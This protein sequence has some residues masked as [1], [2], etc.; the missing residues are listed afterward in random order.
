MIDSFFTS[1]ALM[2]FPNTGATSINKLL[3]I[4]NSALRIATGYVGMTAFDHFHSEASS[5]KVDEH[6]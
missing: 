3:I 6:L 2:W 1:A 5:L 4:Q